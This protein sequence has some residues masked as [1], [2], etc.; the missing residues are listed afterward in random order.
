MRGWLALALGLA[1]TAAAAAV[2]ANPPATTGAGA[3]AQVVLPHDGD[4]YSALV[5]RAAAGDKSV[6][7]RALRM[8]YLKSAARKRTGNLFAKRKALFSAVEAHDDTAARDAAIAVLSADYTDLA[9]QKLL[10]QSCQNLGDSACAE[11]SHFV[12]F[13]LLT[14]ITQSGDG[15]TCKT[16][17]EVVSIAEEFFI[18]AMQGASLRE[19]ALVQNCDRMDVVDGSGNPAVYYFRIDAE[20]E[21]E[22]NM[23]K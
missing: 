4:D 8:T 17:W 9:G 22:E 16:G 7:F 3:A 13:G 20:M 2:N 18:L 23:F 15:K 10:R 11:Q 12:E 1:A 5:A 21:D 19:Q 6:D 14:S